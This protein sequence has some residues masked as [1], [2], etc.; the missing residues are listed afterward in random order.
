MRKFL[1]IVLVIVSL[2]GCNGF[3]KRL[4]PPDNTMTEY[5]QDTPE[6]ESS[7]PL[8][9]VLSLDWND[10]R[11]F[12][13]RLR[14]GHQELLLGIKDAPEY[15]IKVDISSNLKVITG[16]E[17]IQFVN[18]E[19]QSL[20]KLVFHI[21]PSLFGSK[22]TIS[23]LKINQIPSSY[24][25]DSSKGLLTIDL[26]SPSKV[27]EIVIV[28]MEFL[29]SM[30]SDSSSNYNI[31]SSKDGLVTLAHFY[32]MLAVFD[33]DGWHEELP[34]LLG[35]VTY[36]DA[37][38]YIVAV[39]APKEL[40][41]IGSGSII[42]S[43]SDKYRQTVVFSAA[44]ARDFFLAA[45]NDLQK[46]S[47]KFMDI[48]INS[49]AP[50]SLNAGSLAAVSTAE[51]AIEVFDKLIGEYPYSEFDVIATH[52][53]ALGVEYPGLTTINQDLY[54]V[55]DTTNGIPVRVYQ[56]SVITHEVGHQWFYNMVGNDQLNDPWLDESLTQFITYDFYRTQYG[57]KSAKNYLNSFYDRWDSVSREGIPI[58][59]PVSEYSDSNYGAI[60][61]GRGPIFF[62]ILESK[63][64]EEKMGRFLE[65]YFKEYLWKNVTPMDLQAKIES[66]C[67]CDLSSEFISWVGKDFTQ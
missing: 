30:P 53:S 27:G 10:S 22:V 49:Y 42:N 19:D 6:V 1:V 13:S 67:E 33:E 3:E 35:D 46:Q 54:Y 62:S 60:I 14:K 45:G 4:N 17:T 61:Y 37:A 66:I 48:T 47:T 55:D 40:I 31:F 29:Y 20:N 65:E 34:A 15:H 63:I 11:N 44:P 9:D 26:D 8:I 58:G 57:E 24:Q 41:L 52:T 38:S 50:S 7:S 51:K 59:L 21:Y 2:S 23:N 64:G 28:S 16:E 25:L 32:P 5:P 56:E 12:I 36:S 39:T 43:A 18:T